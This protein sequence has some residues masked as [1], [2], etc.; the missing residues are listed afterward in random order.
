MIHYNTD[1]RKIFKAWP[2]EIIDSSVKDLVNRLMYRG[3]DNVTVY[4]SAEL[5]TTNFRSLQIYNED[6]AILEDELFSRIADG[7]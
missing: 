3:S 1:G 2:G 4:G 6:I 5:A 7:I